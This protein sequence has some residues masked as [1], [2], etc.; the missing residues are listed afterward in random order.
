MRIIIAI[1][2]LYIGVIPIVA[3]NT[4]LEKRISVTLKNTSMEQAV[5]K[6][7]KAADI[8]VSYSSDLFAD[9]APVSVEE[10]DQMLLTV[11]NKLFSP[12]KIAYTVHAGQLII[13]PK[14]TMMVKEYRIRGSFIDEETREPVSYATLQI[15]GKPKGVIADH[16]GYFELMLTEIEL[17]DSLAASCLGYERCTFTPDSLLAQPEVTITMK[18]RSIDM[19]PVVISAGKQTKDYK[20]VGNRSWFTTGSVYLDTHGQQIALYIE[21]KKQQKGYIRKVSYHLSDKGNVEAPFRVRILSLDEETGGPGKDLLTE[22]LVVQPPQDTKGWYDVNL[23]EYN[24]SLP[25]DGF[26]VAIQGVFPND[27]SYYAN[28]S[29][30]IERGK[31]NPKSSASDDFAP[32]SIHY[33]QRINYSGKGG[34][35]TWHYSLSH[36]WFQM[37]KDNYS[38]KI[39]AEIGILGR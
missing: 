29:G 19:E 23:A 21:N 13:F 34:G 4:V 25:P 5:E 24:I 18:S 2:C 30:A 32:K 8:H 16:E 1:M 28:E 35:N 11:L 17:T 14:R 10:K 27:Y 20:K 22:I 38:V 12:Y 15:K 9:C 36:Q 39:S 3:Q 31:R 26:F 6:I 7:A 37:E 33:G